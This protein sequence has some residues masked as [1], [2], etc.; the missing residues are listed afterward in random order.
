M[1][2]DAILLDLSLPGL[3]G[4][5][6]L[7]RLK[8]DRRTIDIPVVVL[9]AF[10][11]LSDRDF[12]ESA[13]AWLQKP[14]EE[15]LL[16]AELSRVLRPGSEPARVLLVEDDADL[17]KVI[18][19]TFERAGIQ[20]LHAPTRRRAIEECLTLRPH[21]LILDLALPDGD[22]FGVVDWLRQ[23]DDL[24]Q[25]PLVVY[26]AQDLTEEERK[27]LQLGPTEFLTKARVQLHD[28]ET[29]VLT[30]L[31]Q[32]RMVPEVTLNWDGAASSSNL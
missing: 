12:D 17:A 21:L 3:H 24:K 14:L 31:R 6:I 13:D 27:K 15:E 20:A 1:R 4:W 7:R 29:L 32:Y 9:S 19:T 26:S 5:E 16:L 25:L 10:G 22:G 23:Q 2:V 18:L 28:V 30:M 8:D 11:A